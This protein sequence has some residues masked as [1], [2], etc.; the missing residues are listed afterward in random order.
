MK[1]FP[2]LNGGATRSAGRVF[3]AEIRGETGRAII[4]LYVWVMNLR[5]A[6]SAGLIKLGFDPK[7]LIQCGFGSIVRC[8]R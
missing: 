2:A 8:L 1:E 5:F 4:S 3:L 7:A 6:A